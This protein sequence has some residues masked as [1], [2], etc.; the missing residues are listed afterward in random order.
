MRQKKTMS[1]VQ[2]TYSYIKVIYVHNIYFLFQKQ[3]IEETKKKNTV[4]R[5]KYICL[6]NKTT[7]HVL[8]MTTTPKNKLCTSNNCMYTM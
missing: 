8:R 3:K 2:K 1:T 5:A 7:L 4:N 6:Q